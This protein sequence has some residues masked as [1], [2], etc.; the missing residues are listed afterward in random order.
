[1]K[2]QS[3]NNVYKGKKVFITGHTGFKGSWLSQWLI[4]L[5]AEVTGFSIDLP[6]QPSH[7]ELVDLCHHLHHRLG[8]IRNRE[9]L[10]KVIQEA[11]PDIVFHLAAQALVRD[12]YENPKA[13]FDTNVTGT[14]NLLDCLRHTSTVRAAVLI[15]TD[16]CYENKE[17]EY[18]Y[19][20]IDPLGGKD[21][22]SASK[23][24]A[25][26]AFHAYY[27]SF[28]RSNSR[29]KIASARAGNV[30]GGGDWA[31]DRIVPD[32]VRAWSQNQE[33]IIRNPQSIRPWQ[34]VLEP[35][36]GYLWLGAQLL[37][38]LKG[39][40]GESFN[41]GSNQ[42]THRT[43]EQL[44]KTMQ[45]TW[46]N[47]QWKHHHDETD[48]KK[49]ASTLILNCDRSLSR[50]NWRST[51]SFRESVL[52]TAEWYQNFYQNRTDP[53]S[54]TVSQIQNYQN[55]AIERGQAWLMG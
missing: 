41:F 55:L 3:F 51:L 48:G 40:H 26:L 16:K 1:M 50:L 22:Y 34:H 36:S 39:T 5:G 37:Q 29:L 13:T 54:L 12:S 25:E 43:V 38:N 2:I 15:A 24:C 19:R 42:E 49:E 28:F 17:W 30:I 27:E 6:S 9:E 35:L 46:S 47:A 11:S 4:E 23:A 31:K 52:M 32:C 53:K 33:V 8:D 10:N 7:F 21:P 20:E 18:G 45:K 14:V 44:I